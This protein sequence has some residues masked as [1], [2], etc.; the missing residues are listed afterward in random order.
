MSYFLSSKTTIKLFHNEV[1]LWWIL[2][3]NLYKNLLHIFDKFLYG[4]LI[5]IWFNFLANHF[6]ILDDISK[7]ISLKIYAKKS[8]QIYNFTHRFLNSNSCK[9]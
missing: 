6:K 2:F 3:K 1:R 4:F 8:T 5:E 7:Q 9:F